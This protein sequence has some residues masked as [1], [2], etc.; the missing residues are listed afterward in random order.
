MRQNTLQPQ[1]IAVPCWEDIPSQPAL[2]SRFFTFSHGGIHVSFLE[3]KCILKSMN[4]SSCCF[5]P[6]W[7]ICLW[8]FDHFPKNRDKN[9]TYLK[10]PTL[11]LW[12]SARSVY[13]PAIYLQSA[14]VKTHR[15]SWISP[16][17]EFET[18][19]SN[20][21]RTSRCYHQRSTKMTMKNGPIIQRFKILKNSSD[22]LQMQQLYFARTWKI[23]GDVVNPQKM[24]P[25]FFS[26]TLIPPNGYVTA[27]W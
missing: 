2:L 23:L 6:I 9:E 13:L 10:Q 21:V 4:N 14:A 17:S 3:S 20:F 5:Q 19:G 26:W 1:S 25:K 7:K 22:F 24:I 18:P 11:R 15:R 16:L 12:C 8:N 27:M